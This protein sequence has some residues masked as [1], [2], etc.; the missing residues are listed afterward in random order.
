MPRRAVDFISYSDYERTGT[1]FPVLTRTRKSIG[2]IY[3]PWCSTTV[4]GASPDA[5][6]RSAAVKHWAGTL[7]V[8]AAAVFFVVK[9]RCARHFECAAPVPGCPA[10]ELCLRRTP[11][12][13]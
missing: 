10:S 9:Q 8:I 1:E 11:G 13:A 6:P 2:S 3:Q 12:L 7:L 5:C 4:P